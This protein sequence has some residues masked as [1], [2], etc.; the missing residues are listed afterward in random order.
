MNATLIEPPPDKAAPPPE[1]PDDRGDDDRDDD[2][3]WVTVA[4]FWSAPEAHLARLRLESNDIDCIILDENLVSTDWLYANAVGGI[5]VQVPASRAAYAKDL[6]EG[7]ADDACVVADQVPGESVGVD[8]VVVDYFPRHANCPACGAP[9]PHRRVISRAAA[10]WC[11]LLLGFPLPLVT[12]GLK[13]RRCGQ[14][15]KSN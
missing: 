15:F 4:T 6:L 1:T 5:K 12:R 10:M 11:V 3:P 7:P 14:E 9:G 8:T 13:C 2:G